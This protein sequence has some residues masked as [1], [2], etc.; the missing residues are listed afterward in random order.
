MVFQAKK[1]AIKIYSLYPIYLIG[2]KMK[3]YFV[4]NIEKILYVIVVV[5][6]K[7]KIFTWINLDNL[8]CR[9]LSDI[10]KILFEPNS[11]C[12]ERCSF[13]NYKEGILKKIL[14]S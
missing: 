1:M 10:I 13:E 8:K 9:E 6:I 3:T 5:I 12:C 7:Q 4:L 11:S 14:F 2:L